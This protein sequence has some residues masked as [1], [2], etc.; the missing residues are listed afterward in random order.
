MSKTSGPNPTR[1]NL[2]LTFLKHPPKSYHVWTMSVGP[3]GYCCSHDFS[4]N[5]KAAFVWIILK[6]HFVNFVLPRTRLRWKRWWSRHFERRRRKHKMLIVLMLLLYLLLLLSRW[7][8]DV[9][10]P[11]HVVGRAGHQAGERVATFVRLNLKKLRKILFVT[12]KKKKI[13]ILRK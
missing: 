3:E 12:F 4:L 11:D 8:L 6:F 9:V 13:C 10:L 2:L 7:L 5:F 1:L